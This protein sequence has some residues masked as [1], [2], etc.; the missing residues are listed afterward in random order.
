MQRTCTD[1]SRRRD[2]ADAASGRVERVRV[3]LYACRPDGEAGVLTEL[4]VYAT[5][6]D[7]VVVGEL[8]DRTHPDSALDERP[9]WTRLKELVESGQAQGIVTP[10]RRLC[11]K[12][13][14]ERSLLDTW[15]AA[16]RAFVVTA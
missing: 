9:R 3:V 5:A 1:F 10:M 2:L 8:I 11:G 14:S 6:R 12:C 13:E 15:L 4:R 7:W 16:H